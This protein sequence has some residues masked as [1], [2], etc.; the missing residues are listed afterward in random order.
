M[1][2][3]RPSSA[4]STGNTGF[5]F[6]TPKLS[7]RTYGQF[8]RISVS[9]L[10]AVDGQGKF[11]LLLS[12][13][14]ENARRAGIARPIVVGALPFDPQQ[15]TSLFVPMDYAFEPRTMAPRQPSSL[16]RLLKATPSDRV[17][18]EQSVIKILN[19]LDQRGLRKVVLSRTLDLLYA[20][21]IDT[22]AILVCLANAHPAAYSFR[23]TLGLSD[24]WLGASPELL[25]AKH[26]S[27]VSSLPLAGSAPRFACTD[28]DR[29][30]ADHLQSSF[31][32]LHEHRFVVDDIEHSLRPLCN[33]LEIPKR[34]SLL[35]TDAMWHLAS[36]IRGTLTRP[37]SNS[38]QLAA[39]LH[40]TPA[41][42]GSP[43]RQA[44]EA[45]SSLEL[46]QRG[47]Y[48]GMVGWSDSDGNG[49][50]AVTLRCAHVQGR[51]ARLFAGAGIV[52]G[53]HP[54]DEWAETDAKLR[55]LMRVFNPRP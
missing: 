52:Q 14:F 44:R 6:F 23:L 26:N 8:Q 4:L 50:W 24:C 55:T 34:P 18:F 42:C 27:K 32:D 19:V 48:S 30:A 37:D 36:N 31:K 43:T 29:R 41:V 47:L 51:Q 11:Q 12:G 22:Q 49:E 40:P 1:E 21:T 10:D 39:L 5:E 15:P 46:H 45:I 9:A 53:S 3:A 17:Q 35:C 2:S 33:T 20:E 25:I 38:L 54:A 13:V 16:N 28:A 7:L